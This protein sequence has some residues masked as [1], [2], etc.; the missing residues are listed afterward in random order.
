MNEGYV[1]IK[2]Q[3]WSPLILLARITSDFIR[4][5]LLAWCEHKW[6]S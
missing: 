5:I 6:A 4:V 1:E 3:K 2:H